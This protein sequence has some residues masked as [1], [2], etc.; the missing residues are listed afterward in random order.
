MEIYSSNMI[1]VTYPDYQT[2]N[3]MMVSFPVVGGQKFYKFVTLIDYFPAQ[4]FNKVE[5]PEQS[6]VCPRLRNSD[7]HRHSVCPPLRNR[8]MGRHS[9]CPPFRDKDMGR[10]SVCPPL[11]NSDI[12]RHSVCPLLRN[13]DMHPAFNGATT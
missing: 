6:T 8:E 7:M 10:D 1:P 5:I 13:S 2:S 9:V 3:I 11:I 12:R 4:I